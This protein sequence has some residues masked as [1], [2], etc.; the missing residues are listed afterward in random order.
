MM[1]SI[2]KR[3]LHA[4]SQHNLV[5]TD[6]V[7]AVNNP[8]QQQHPPHWRC[9]N[10]PSQLVGS[11]PF[12]ATRLWSPVSV[13]VVLMLRLTK[14]KD[15]GEYRYETIIGSYDSIEYWYWLSLGN[16]Q[17]NFVSAD[18]HAGTIVRADSCNHQFLIVTIV[19]VHNYGEYR[20]EMII[21]SKICESIDTA[22]AGGIAVPISW[23][24]TIVR[25]I[26]QELVLVSNDSW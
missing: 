10:Y 15:S 12:V 16:C 19:G 1:V 8:T 18:N 23:V 26:L 24:A 20:F 11:L 2:C 14:E 25:G 13:I 3:Y 4:C 17:P 6:L 5:L 7:C 21:G 22:W 9:P